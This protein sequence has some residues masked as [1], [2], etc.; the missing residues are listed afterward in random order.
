MKVILAR[1]AGFCM[2]VK[3]AVALV[4]D[5]IDGGGTKRIVT[6]GPLIHNPSFL[7]ELEKRGVLQL[8]SETEVEEN[9]IVVVRTHGISRAELDK[10]NAKQIEIV[11]ATCPKVKASQNWIRQKIE[12]RTLIV[13]GDARHGEVVSL[14]SYSDNF[15]VLENVAAAIN[16]V[17]TTNIEKALFV[18]QTTF[19]QEE[20]EKILSVLQENICDLLVRNSICDA[21]FKRQEALK[22]ILD[23]CD[24]LFVVGGKQSANTTRLAA[25]AKSSGK[26]TFHIENSSEIDLNFL[27]NSNFNVAGVSAGASTP[28]CD[29]EE[30]VKLLK[31]I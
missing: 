11:D 5:L 28:S 9:D 23:C 6:L 22:E 13:S 2:G 1:E 7:G 19:S 29:I 31:E 14:C 20:F 4:N 10:L 8:K 16:L 27:K 21:T 3:R 30:V 15:Y 25:T 24:C 18:S 12:G 17:Q 26:P